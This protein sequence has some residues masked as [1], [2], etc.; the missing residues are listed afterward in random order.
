MSPTRTCSTWV[1]AVFQLLSLVLLVGAASAAGSATLSVQPQAGEPASKVSVSGSGMAAFEEVVL[2]YDGAALATARANAAGSFE[3][4]GVEIPAS[5]LPG[6]RPL[7]AVG[8][9]SGTRATALFLVRSNWP[10]FHRGSFRHGEVPHENVLGPD[11]VS[12]LRLLW[13]VPSGLHVDSAI[14][15][16]P[17]VANGLVFI[18]ASDHKQGR[19]LALDAATGARRWTKPLGPSYWCGTTPA[20]AQG[21]VY[22]PVAGLMTAYDARS[23]TLR[24]RAGESDCSVPATPTLAGGKLF[25]IA[26]S[27]P[28]LQARD[29]ASGKLLWSALACVGPSDSCESIA[30]IFGPLAAGDGAVYATTYVGGMMAFDANTGRKRWSRSVGGGYVIDS[31]PVVEGDVVYI[32][33]HDSRLYALNR[34]TG[35]TLWSAPTGDYNHA[36]PALADGVLY[37]GSDG[38]GLRAIDAKTGAKRWE[39]G[40]VGVVRTSPAVANGVVY[41]GA[42]DGRLY[43]LHAQTGAVLYSRQVAPA[44]RLLS[45]SPAV[46]DGVVYVGTGDRMM[47]FGLKSEAAATADTER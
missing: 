36:T 6:R 30:S 8:R 27:G 22:A 3:K 24:W 21:R 39:Q 12:Q 18:L 17:V 25:T 46:V 15:G 32:S 20:V 33:V 10:Q 47:A 29:A 11:N 35:A 13:N 43:A 41:L 19:L 9:S 4:D 40:A 5:A 45:P 38:N 28:Y 34:H 2:R 23:G 37:V 7:A 26:A 16:S 44:G 42:G 14:Q 1:K 31:A